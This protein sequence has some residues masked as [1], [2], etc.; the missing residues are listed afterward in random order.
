MQ[1]PAHGPWAGTELLLYQITKLHQRRCLIGC[2]YSAAEDPIQQ[3]ALMGRSHLP[4]AKDA[5]VRVDCPE[6]FQS[7]LEVARDGGPMLRLRVLMQQMPLVC[8]LVDRPFHPP[9][10]LV[11]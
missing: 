1:G 5:R 8:R 2:V 10:E 11:D 3:V 4:V 6:G 7:T 9:C